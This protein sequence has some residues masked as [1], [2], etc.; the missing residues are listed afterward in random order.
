MTPTV[1]PTSMWAKSIPRTNNDFMVIFLVLVFG[2]DP[3]VVIA[4]PGLTSLWYV[5]L[6]VLAAFA[7]FYCLENF[8][9]RKR[10]ANTTS[11]LDKW[12]FPIIVIRNVIFLLN[13]IPVMQLLGLA[14]LGSFQT[15]IPGLGELDFVDLGG[16]GLLVPTVL[17]LYIYIIIRRYSS[18]KNQPN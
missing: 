15:I 14:L 1:A 13:F 17:I 4:Y 16:F 5:M 10:F 9:F 8:V 11:F 3:L 12:I 6:G 18:T 2:L 7:V